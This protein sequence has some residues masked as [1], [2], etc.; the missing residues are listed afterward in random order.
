MKPPADP[1]A[2][3]FFNEIGI[4]EHLART[5]AERVMPPGLSMAGF[6]VLNHMIRMGHVR[7]APSRIAGALQVTKAAVTGT[8]KRLE[9]EGWVVVEADPADGRGKAVSVTPAGRAVRDAAV[10]S[11]EPLFRELFSE[12][13]EAELAA[14]LP[15]LQKVRR[16]LDEARD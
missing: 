14:L 9:A 16:L 6:T 3:V 1:T 8:L 4:I 15:T 11:L 2:F 10:A 12:V 5:A 13:D 7:R